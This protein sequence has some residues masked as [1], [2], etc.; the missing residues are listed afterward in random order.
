MPEYQF[1]IRYTASTYIFIEA[2]SLEEAKEEVQG[3]LE[4]QVDHLDYYEIKAS[5]E[6][7]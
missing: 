6:K 5:Q 2:N 1:D 3:E 4:L 7:P